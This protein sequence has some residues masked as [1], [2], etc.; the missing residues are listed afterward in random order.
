MNTMGE[1]IR[2]IRTALG[3]SQDYVAKRLGITQQAYSAI[4]K[5]PEHSAL[6]RLKEVSQVLQVTLPA[7]IGEDESLLQTNVQQQGG[8]AATQM[9]FQGTA[10]ARNELYERYILELKTET[11]HL[12]EEIRFL[13]GLIKKQE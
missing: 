2:R 6:Q 4:E 7:L 5:N 12:R 3:Y 10:D 8:H 11:E 9:I 13:R 1:N